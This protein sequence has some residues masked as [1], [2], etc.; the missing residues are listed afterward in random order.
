MAYRSKA[1]TPQG[2]TLARREAVIEAFT[3]LVL[4]VPEADAGDIA[5]LLGPI[6]DAQGWE[7]L[8]EQGSLPSSKTLV[9]VQLRVDSLSRKPSDNPT[10]T[11]FYLL[12]E[13]ARLDTGEVLRFTAGG[14]QAVA[15]LSKLHQLKALPAFVRFDSVSTRS[16]NDAINCTVLG[17]DPSRIIDG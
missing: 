2:S 4:Q 13:G 11:G 8:G 1:L 6:L 17:R 14:E 10:R 16:G 5:D 3:D 7:Q 15:V 12:A 9:G